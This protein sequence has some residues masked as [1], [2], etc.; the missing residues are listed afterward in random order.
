M[1]IYRN[2]MYLY[3]CM[4]RR[5]SDGAS[6]CQCEVLVLVNLAT[7]C[8]TTFSDEVVRKIMAWNTYVRILHMRAGL[9]QS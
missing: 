1:F 5:N 6:Y 9:I 4:K 7:I 3:V 8:Y 2:D